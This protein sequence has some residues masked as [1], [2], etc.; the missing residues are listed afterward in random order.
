MKWLGRICDRIVWHTETMEISIIQA[1]NSFNYIRANL[2]SKQLLYVS[3][4]FQRSDANE[5]FI[6]LLSKFCHP[7]DVL[8]LTEA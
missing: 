6:A 8:T 2:L 1:A 3:N 7:L 4:G 5:H